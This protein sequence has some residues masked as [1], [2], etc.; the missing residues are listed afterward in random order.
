MNNKPVTV[1][2]SDGETMPLKLNIHLPIVDEDLQSTQSSSFAATP[3]NN[4]AHHINLRLPTIVPIRR[5]YNGMNTLKALSD[6]DDSDE[7]VKTLLKYKNQDKTPDDSTGGKTYTNKLTKQ[8]GEE[9]EGKEEDLKSDEAKMHIERE[10]STLCNPFLKLAPM[11]YT[12]NKMKKHSSQARES[13]RDM[14][15]TSSINVDIYGR[16]ANNVNKKT[17]QSPIQTEKSGQIK[18]APSKI[19]TLLPLVSAKYQQDKMKQYNP[20]RRFPTVTETCTIPDSYN[21]NTYPSVQSL[22]NV[23]HNYFDSYQDKHHSRQNSKKVDRIIYPSRNGFHPRSL[24]PTYDKLIKARE[25]LNNTLGANQ[26]TSQSL[27]YRLKKYSYPTFSSRDDEVNYIKRG[28]KEA[29]NNKRVTIESSDGET[30]PQKMNLHLPIVVKTLQPTQSSSF[31]STPKEVLEAHKNGLRLPTITTIRRPCHGITKTKALSDND[32]CNNIVKYKHL[33]K[34]P[35]GSIGDKKY[36]E[37]FTEQLGEELER[38]EEDLKSEKTKMHLQKDK[39]SLSELYKRFPKPAPMIYNKMKIHSSQARNVTSSGNVHIHGR[40]ANNDDKETLLPPTQIEKPRQIKGNPRKIHTLLLLVSAKDRKHNMKQDSLSELNDTHNETDNLLKEGT[41]SGKSKTENESNKGSPKYG[42]MKTV[43]Y[44]EANKYSEKKTYN[45]LMKIANIGVK[46]TLVYLKED[47]KDGEKRRVGY[48]KED[49]KYDEKMREGYLKEDTKDGEKR[50][51]G[52]LKEDTKYDEKKK[53]S[54]LK[55]SIKYG[56][57]KTKNYLTMDIKHGEKKTQEYK[58]GTDDYEMKT[59]NYLKNET[60]ET[61]ACLEEMNRSGE[62]KYLKH[63]NQ[64]GSLESNLLKYKSQTDK[65]WLSFISGKAPPEIVERKRKESHAER[66]EYL[67]KEETIMKEA[68]AHMMVLPDTHGEMT[69]NNEDTEQTL[70]IA[71]NQET[72]QKTIM[73][74]CDSMKQRQQFQGNIVGHSK[75]QAEQAKEIYEDREWMKRDEEQKVKELE[76]MKNEV[77]EWKQKLLG[78]MT[79]SFGE[80]TTGG[81]E[82]E[83]PVSMI[84]EEIIMNPQKPLVL[85]SLDFDRSKNKAIVKAAQSV[86]LTSE[87]P[88]DL[89]YTRD[90]KIMSQIF[91]D[92]LNSIAF[93]ADGDDGDGDSDDDG[94]YDDYDVDDDNDDSVDSDE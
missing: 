25:H 57:H 88:N 24:S 49:T 31:I 85:K 47:T 84:P 32:D 66:I 27:P 63:D 18:E 15:V 41:I 2:S 26:N 12:W 80:T 33:Y 14:S 90:H 68:N 37:E 64:D 67:S 22:P 39:Q 65:P 71:S 89:Y 51:E 78:S 9:L 43:K 77:I 28:E 93:D 74:R 10:K 81:M 50:R 38:S 4:K 3:K 45:N 92:R 73:S 59:H 21:L 83:K 8:L 61:E 7:V 42:E 23:Y 69:M 36:T 20:I 54:Y 44:K 79:N 6:N 16:S 30:M 1:E 94:Y 29:M 72:R 34:I 87:E 17:L 62:F 35:D 46:Q 82:K 58:E 48:L 55:R 40:K 91:I 56:G 75:S 11:I 76:I 52:Y 60:K 86:G 19:H 5:P 53:A 13:V 70:T